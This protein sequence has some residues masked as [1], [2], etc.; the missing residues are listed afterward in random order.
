M[1]AKCS[2]NY[3]PPGASRVAPS[4]TAASLQYGRLPAWP[5]CAH[6][7][8][9]R[10]LRRMQVFASSLY[11]GEICDPTQRLALSMNGTETHLVR[12]AATCNILCQYA[13]SFTNKYCV[14][15][16]PML[17][18]FTAIS[19]R[20]AVGLSDPGGRLER[21]SLI[22]EWSCRRCVHATLRVGTV[23]TSGASTPPER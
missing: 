20:W 14:S 21:I 9:R 18:P 13:T 5:S 8:S 2:W 11:Y 23:D 12:S 7:R 15:Y 1:Q 6:P 17:A 10:E 19:G 16:K 4:L 3:R 22:W